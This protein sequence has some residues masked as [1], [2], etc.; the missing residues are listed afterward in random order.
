MR[1]KVKVSLLSL[2]F[3]LNSAFEFARKQTV[4]RLHDLAWK[5]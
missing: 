3:F 2:A 1:I 5:I 4:V